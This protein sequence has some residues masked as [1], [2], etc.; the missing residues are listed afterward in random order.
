MTANTIIASKTP[1]CSADVTVA[2]SGCSF[3]TTRTHNETIY[4]NQMK[5]Y[6]VLPETGV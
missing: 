1:L 3:L 4:M 5:K 2:L 6:L